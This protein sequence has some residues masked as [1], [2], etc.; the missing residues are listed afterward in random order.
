QPEAGH[1]RPL[2]SP[3]LPFQA[4][5]PVLVPRD[6]ALLPADG[7][8]LRARRRLYGNPALDLPRVCLLEHAAA[9]AHPGFAGAGGQ[10]AAAAAA[11]RGLDAERGVRPARPDR[12]APQRITTIAGRSV[13]TDAG[14]RMEY[15]LYCLA[16]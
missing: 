15:N 7:A 13:A 12:P 2:H 1:P 4:V 3:G 10:R 6:G 8:A 5:G 11:R 9:D 14:G 16:L